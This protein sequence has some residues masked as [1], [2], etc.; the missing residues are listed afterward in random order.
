MNKFVYSIMFTFMSCY[1][2]KIYSNFFK[3]LND[4]NSVIIYEKRG[5][6]TKKN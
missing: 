5:Q 1:E 3:L 6:K 2:K 4:E